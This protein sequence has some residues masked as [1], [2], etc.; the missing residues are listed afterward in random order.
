MA[1]RTRGSATSGGG[2][3]IPDWA[4]FTPTGSWETNV[5]YTGE[6]KVIADTL[7]VRGKIAFAGPPETTFL[8]INLPSGYAIDETRVAADTFAW[9]GGAIIYD[10]SPVDLYN[11]D[12]LA[13]SNSTVYISVYAVNAAAA[14]TVYTS[15]TAVRGDVAVPI[16]FANADWISYQYSIP[17]ITT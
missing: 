17:V 13:A 11:G 2:T 9:L 6:Y 4:A 5:T 3:T 8:T 15:P 16:T 12:C 1:E 7:H 14:G 10:A